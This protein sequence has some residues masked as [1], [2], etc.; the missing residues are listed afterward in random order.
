MISAHS[1][2]E[3]GLLNGLRKG[4]LLAVR[5]RRGARIESRRGAVWV[6]QDGDPTDVVLNPGETHVLTSDK[7]VLIQ[8][9]DAAWVAVQPR[10]ADRRAGGLPRLWRRLRSAVGLQP[11]AAMAR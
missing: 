4:Q 3:P 5:A 11:V 8:A 6:T 2:R 10:E 1:T 9:L 7:P